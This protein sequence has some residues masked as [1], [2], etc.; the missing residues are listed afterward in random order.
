MCWGTWCR[1]C[2]CWPSFPR[3]SSLTISQPTW[4]KVKYSLLTILQITWRKVTLT[5]LIISQTTRRNVKCSIVIYHVIIPC[6]F[7]HLS[8][9]ISYQLRRSENCW[10]GSNRFDHLQAVN[11]PWKNIWRPWQTINYVDIQ[12]ICYKQRK[13]KKNGERAQES[14]AVVRPSKCL[15]WSYL[16]DQNSL[17]ICIQSIY[18]SQGLLIKRKRK[19]IDRDEDRQEQ[20]FL[21]LN[22]LY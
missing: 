19:N 21:E 20:S 11:A 10:F 3:G 17:Q 9:S 13:I 15:Q 16:L 8:L 22:F 7:L 6:E 2:Q 5:S 12:N 1:W 4:R 14:W 18:I